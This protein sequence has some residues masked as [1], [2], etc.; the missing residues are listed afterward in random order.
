MK[1]D[2]CVCNLTLDNQIRTTYLIVGKY[3]NA[4]SAPDR[5]PCGLAVDIDNEL[6]GQLIPIECQS[7]I[8]TRVVE[9][10]P[11][12]TLSFTSRVAD[13]NFTR[14]YCLQISKCKYIIHTFETCKE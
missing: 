10:I 8:A 6:S 12:G 5:S 11:N 7:G 1:E 13:G 14:G 2:K 3:D 9:I 4:E